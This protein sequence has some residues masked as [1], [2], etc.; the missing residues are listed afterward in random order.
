VGGGDASVSVF[1]ARSKLHGEHA[2]R[3]TVGNAPR[4]V[5]DSRVAIR[6]ANPDSLLAADDRLQTRLR[7]GFYQGSGRVAEQV[8]RPFTFEPVCD[9]VD[10]A[11]ALAKNSA[12]R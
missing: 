6:H 3:G 8:A 11:H 9:Q 12:L 2:R 5:G 1:G 10:C 4:S 7:T